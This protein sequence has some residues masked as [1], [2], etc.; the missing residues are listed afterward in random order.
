[1]ARR[2]DKARFHIARH[3]IEER[4]LA[5][6]R[7][8][9]ERVA[10]LAADGSLLW[11]KDGSPDGVILTPEELQRWKG[12]GHLATHNH[13]GGLPFTVG[14]VCVAAAL[15]VAEL[16]A[17]SRDLRYRMTVMPGE[18]WPP[19]EDVVA[20]CTEIDTAIRS[21]VE[22]QIDNGALTP[23]TALFYHRHSRWRLFARRYAGVVDY[24]V[25]PR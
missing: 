9:W 24:D 19:P 15:A 2:D 3:A 21:V 6:T 16:N 1:M 22:A 12:R 11:T 17:F 18:S 4:I 7:N 20:A 5:V 25:G 13:P 23:E 10:L 14:D 8:R